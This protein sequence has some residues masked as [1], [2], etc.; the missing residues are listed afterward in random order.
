MTVCVHARG[1]YSDDYQ[2]CLDCGREVVLINGAWFPVEAWIRVSLELCEPAVEAASD[3]SA[4]ETKMGNLL[5]DRLDLMIDVV[6]ERTDETVLTEAIDSLHKG[7]FILWAADGS[8]VI[9][10]GSKD[11]AKHGATLSMSSPRQG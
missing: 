11:F 4:K 6:I 8:R 1:E 7:Q 3:T 10:V 2:H 9:R 5:Q